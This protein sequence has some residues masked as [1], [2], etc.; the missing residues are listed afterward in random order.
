MTRNSPVVR[1][2]TKWHSQVTEAYEEVGKALSEGDYQ[3]AA[4]IMTVITQQQAKMS[5]HIRQEANQE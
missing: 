5:L 1:A 3:R 4:D 2:F